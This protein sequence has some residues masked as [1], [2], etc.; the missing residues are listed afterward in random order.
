MGVDDDGVGV[1]VVVTLSSMLAKRAGRALEL[2]VV[3]DAL[4]SA[5]LERGRA[6]G[7]R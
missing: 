2:C 6:V 7:G 4:V 1:G 5:R 3:E